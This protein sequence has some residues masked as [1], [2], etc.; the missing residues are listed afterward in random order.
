MVEDSVLTIDKYASSGNT[1]KLHAIARY[2]AL[3]KQGLSEKARGNCH[4]SAPLFHSAA[5]G[6]QKAGSPFARWAWFQITLC[7]YS[8]FK[9]RSA[10][11]VI[12]K[13]LSLPASE[14]YPALAGN[15]NW[16]KGLI[17]GID[18]DPEGSLLFY[19]RS[20]YQFKLSKEYENCAALE[21]L[22]ANA[23]RA[24]GDLK[25]AWEHSW[26]S[27][28]SICNVR[29]PKKKYNILTESASISAALDLPEAA[30]RFMEEALQ[31]TATVDTTGRLALLRWKAVLCIRL[32]RATAAQESIAAAKRILPQVTDPATREGLRG[33]LLAI[34]GQA[35]ATTN[36]EIALEELTSAIAIYQNT[37]YGKQL[38]EL[39]LQRAA[40]EAALNQLFP[41]ELD[42]KQAIQIIEIERAKTPQ[43]ER[44]A[45]LDERRTIYDHMIRL[46]LRLGREDVAL[47][48]IEQVRSRVLLDTLTPAYNKYFANARYLPAQIQSEVAPKTVL[49][50]YYVLGDEYYAWL[51]TQKAISAVCLGKS[52][53]IDASLG[54]LRLTI[55]TGHA[56]EKTR[57]ELRILFERLITPI[58]PNL[59][60]IDQIVLVPDG[61]L[62]QIPFAALFDNKSS[63]FL[64][65]RAQVTIAPSLLVHL[66]ANRRKHEM[67]ISVRGLSVLA[68]G[69]PQISRLYWPTLSSLQGSE[70]EAKSVA[71]LY[72]TA[73][74]LTG[75]DATAEAFLRQATHYSIIHLATHG[76]SNSPNPKA[77][78]FMLGTEGSERSGVVHDSEIRLLNFRST[79]LVF[80]NICTSLGHKTGNTEGV[81]GLAGA[82]LSAGVPTIIG[83]LW[84]VED[85]TSKLVEHFH[86][87]VA[88]GIDPSLALRRVQIE[89]IRRRSPEDSFSWA[90]FE[91][92]GS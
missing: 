21:A 71:R 24:L 11:T 69:G 83:T 8:S 64:I 70:L 54:N 75:A 18:G 62:F 66:E 87:W 76:I 68:I 65:E 86:E 44:E 43:S 45:F 10:E 9:Y 7:H 22:I 2:H 27:L 20:L 1:R 35:L 53:E 32:G 90:A 40:V 5:V 48:Y 41:A 17:R 14:R 42:L 26:L 56:A 28:Q 84:D 19:R 4:L 6:L 12:D 46:Q 63:R 74:L 57:A 38:G 33:D 80:L 81:S 89:A 39:L 30:L 59:E 73:L 29:D 85:R 49:V 51:I 47:S 61:G 34:E 88:R 60:S 25:T 92:Y 13:T 15:F 79:R 91:A 31:K 50:E 82:F 77:P 37:D 78:A 72:K 55:G 23:F 58:L 36:P 52:A 3:Y 67:T 16:V